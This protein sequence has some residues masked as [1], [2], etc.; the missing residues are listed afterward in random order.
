MS[1]TYM[2][3]QL[4]VTS[5]REFLINESFESI[6]R[7]NGVSTARALYEILSEPVKNVLKERGTGRVFL[8]DP[9]GGPDIECYLKRYLQPSMKDRIKCATAFKPVFSSG[10]LHEWTALCAFHREG[11]NT[12]TPIAAGFFADKTCNLTLG[13]K[14]YVRASELFRSELKTDL[15]RRRN[16]IIKIAEYVAR[17]HCA[18]LAHQDFYLVHLFIKPDEG[19]AIYLIDLQRVIMQKHLARRW[20]IK[21]LA[22]IHFSLAPFISA[23]EVALF[24]QTYNTAHP[25]PVK[26]WNTIEKKAFRIKKHAEKKGMSHENNRHSR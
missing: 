8:R 9:R 3:I 19:D 21:D 12:M 2:E 5:T 11:L 20:I 26:I 23:K 4:S 17:M 1:A 24:Q 25:V 16:L 6:L 18:G 10:A 22:Q 7:F 13:I 14:D 15:E